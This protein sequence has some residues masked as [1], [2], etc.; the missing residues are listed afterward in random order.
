VVLLALADPVVDMV[1]VATSLA[2]QGGWAVAGGGERDAP[3]DNATYDEKY[4]YEPSEPFHCSL[5]S[6]VA[7]A[8]A[9]CYSG[10]IISAP[11]GSVITETS[12]C[13]GG[14]LDKFR[15]FFSL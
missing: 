11:D 4:H 13:I 14:F 3:I 10:P 6:S 9:G 2:R 1:P 8:A 15:R 5:Q 7:P 12:D